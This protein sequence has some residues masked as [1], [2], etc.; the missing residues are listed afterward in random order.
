MTAMYQKPYP[1]G[2]TDGEPEKR[3]LCPHEEVIGYRLDCS[4]CL[5]SKEGLCDYPYI[6]AR[7]TPREEEPHEC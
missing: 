4:D 7:K 3:N 2:G 5:Y 6:G 1:M